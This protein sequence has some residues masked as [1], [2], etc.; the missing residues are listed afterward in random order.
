MITLERQEGLVTPLVDRLG[1]C[2]AIVQTSPQAAPVTAEL[3]GGQ[4]MDYYL[5]VS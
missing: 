1:H 4:Y 2:P 3:G 5:P